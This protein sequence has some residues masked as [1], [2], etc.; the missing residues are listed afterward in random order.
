MPTVNIITLGE[1]DANRFEVD[2]ATIDRC[3]R[4]QRRPRPPRT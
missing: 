1:N 3:R 2:Q 4:P